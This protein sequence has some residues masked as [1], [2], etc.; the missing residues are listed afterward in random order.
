MLFTSAIFWVFFAIVLLCLEVN[1]RLL[2]SIK[3]QNLLLLFASYFFY[4]YWDWHFLSLI[5]LV[6]V[7][8][9]IAA[10]I[11]SDYK[12]LRK[13]ALTLSIVLNLAVLFYF[14]Y[15]NFFVT[16]FSSAF[17]VKNNFSLE[18]IILP[19]GI[20]FYIFQSFTYV[21]DVFYNKISPEKDAIKYF[22]F[23]AFFPQLVAGPIERASTFL[24][25]FNNLKQV[26]I[27]NVYTGLKI[28]I[29]GLFLK[30]FIADSIA[31][32]TDQI[33][34][35]YDTF[36]GGTLLL[37]AIGFMFQIYGDFAGYSL[38]AIGVAKIM[39]FDLMR[40]FNTPYFSISIQDFWRRWH[41]SLSSFF[42]DYVYIPLGGSR[43]NNATT[44]RNLTVTF[45]VSGLW[46]GA[47]WTFIIW[48]LAHG[49]LLIIQRIL[50]I[51]VNKF[52]GW[53]STMCLV[54]ILWILFRSESVNDF[55]SYLSIIFLNP[56]IPDIGKDIIIYSMYCFLL[57]CVLF[58]YKEQGSLWFRSIALE[59]LILAT[60]LITV[61]GAMHEQTQNF[62]YFQF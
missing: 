17:G 62:I 22:T 2:K 9:F 58:F 39:D 55:Y 5:F 25:Q 29:I 49:S 41:I 33:F 56:G 11:I 7:Q 6:T 37:G 40:N 38:I 47:N 26:S 18:N 28:I 20:S 34:A 44:N 8:T 1:Y 45:T 32:L 61:I 19:V 42:R 10:K 15:A 31:P 21:L 60:M 12:N 53:F 14:K 3:F 51:T 48:G 50:P 16:E 46:H 54:L 35:N 27:D 23:I 59:T 52:I 57:D 4:G 43:W 13:L 24:P 36:N 30:I